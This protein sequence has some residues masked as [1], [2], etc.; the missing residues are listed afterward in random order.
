MK[1][2]RCCKCKETK[3][4]SE[5]YKNRSRKDGQT[6][7][8]KMCIKERDRRYRDA[9]REAVNERGRRYYEK[10]KE[11]I[12]EKGR[13]YYQANREKVAERSRRYR[14][15]NREEI[16][17]KQRKYYEANR[18]QFNRRGT[19]FI[20]EANER[21]LELAHRQGLPWADWEDEFVM[22]DNDLTVYQKAVKLERSYSSVA[23]RRRGL[24]KKLVTS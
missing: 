20:K 9:N 13:R 21:S 19:K 12:A 22:A 16:A 23:S 1:T 17:K 14:E 10:N 24:R 11:K 5:F 6:E 15:S 7:E 3:P 18:E 8:C 2:K 4:V